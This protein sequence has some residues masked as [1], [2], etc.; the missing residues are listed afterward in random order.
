M[1]QNTPRGYTYPLYTDPANPPAQIEDFARDVDLDVAA[2]V[3]RIN[4]ALAQ[5]SARCSA[6]AN[7]AIAANTD[8]FATFAVED[9]DNAAMVN[10]GVN[11]DR[12]TFTATGLYLV[13][14]EMNWAPNGNA[15]VGGRSAILIFNLGGIHEARQSLRGHLTFDTELC[16]QYLYQVNTIGDF[17]RVRL[18]Q[19]SG[20]SANV[21]ARSFSAT[22][23]AD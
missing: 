5:P 14:A 13:S 18:R 21:S 4:S 12:I 10:L 3:A 23:V 22:K 16:V 7:Q 20:A 1:P 19:S 8:T 11:N 15:T 6:S 17:A 2:Q 9:Y